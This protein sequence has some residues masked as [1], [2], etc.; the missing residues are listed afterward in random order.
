MTQLFCHTCHTC[1]LYVLAGMTVTVILMKIVTVLIGHDRI[2]GILVAFHHHQTR[3]TILRMNCPIM[4]IAIQNSNL[5]HR[6]REFNKTMCSNVLNRYHEFHKTLCSNNLLRKYQ[7]FKQ[8]FCDSN[9]Q[10]TNI[11]IYIYIQ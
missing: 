10:V 8:T 2:M 1:R 5:Q 3:I 6:C 7:V 9:L 11:Y 4:K